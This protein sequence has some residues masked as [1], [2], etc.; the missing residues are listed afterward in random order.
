MFNMR[1]KRVLYGNT[2]FFYYGQPKCNLKVYTL[3]T[4][5]KQEQKNKTRK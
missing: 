4:G 1:A 3:K 2:V 5:R